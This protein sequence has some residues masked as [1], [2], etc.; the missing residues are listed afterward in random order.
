M[1][2]LASAKH[3]DESDL[4]AF[5]EEA[6]DV[7]HLEVHVVLVGLR[8]ELDL[9]RL[10]GRHALLLL[11]L[12]LRLFVLELAVVHDPAHRR[13]GSWRDLDEIEALVLGDAQRLIRRHDAELLAFVD[14]AHLLGTDALVDTMPLVGATA[15][16]AAAGV[17]ATI[18][19]LYMRWIVLVGRFV[20]QDAAACNS[21]VRGSR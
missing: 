12:L 9:L 18:H 13:N 14:D 8:P 11:L 19:W 1:S 5:F 16:E 4:V 21:I 10:E 20:R 6:P 7:L 3:D 17:R 2:H 15:I